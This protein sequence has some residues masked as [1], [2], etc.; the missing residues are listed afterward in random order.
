MR[1]KKKPYDGDTRVR[2]GFLWFPKEC[3]NQVRW[4][5]HARWREQYYIGV[6][7]SQWVGIKWLDELETKESIL[8]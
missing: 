2:E 5:E 7:I 6:W 1:F 8:N 4:L 3:D